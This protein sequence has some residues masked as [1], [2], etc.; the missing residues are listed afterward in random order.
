MTHRGIAR[1]YAAALFDVVSKSGDP[2]RARRDLDEV[3]GV[4][5]GHEELAR[6]LENPAIAPAKKRAVITEILKHGDVMAEVGRLLLMLA[7]QDRLLLVQ[8][9]AEM[10]GQR[11]MTA[12]RVLPAEV[13]TASPLSAASR[14]KLAT[15]L[16]QATGSDV[17]LTERVDPAIVGGVVAKVGSVVFDGSVTRQIEKMRQKLLAEA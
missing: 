14:E 10:F 12:S 11:V 8:E 15:A 3:A 2:A 17:T 4:I 7:D 5:R 13:V 1:R 6:V 16:G 9:I